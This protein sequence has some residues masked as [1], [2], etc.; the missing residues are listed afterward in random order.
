MHSRLSPSPTLHDRINIIQTHRHEE[1][2]GKKIV[3]AHRRNPFPSRHC[4]HNKINYFGVAPA[5]LA[6]SVPAPT[7]RGLARSPNFV[8]KGSSSDAE[9]KDEQKVRSDHSMQTTGAR[10]K[11]AYLRA[12]RNPAR[13]WSA[14]GGGSPPCRLYYCGGVVNNWPTTQQ[15]RMGRCSEYLKNFSFNSLRERSGKKVSITENSVPH[16]CKAYSR[17]RTRWIKWAWVNIKR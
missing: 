3:V 5:A 1:K 6:S 17:K 9:R 10:G 4:S 8:S 7:L 2:V 12:R 15:D 13:A 14:L 11:V 16:C